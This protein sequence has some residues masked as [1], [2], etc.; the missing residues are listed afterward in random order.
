[1]DFE[2]LPDALV[3]LTIRCSMIFYE[4]TSNFSMYSGCSSITFFFSVEGKET[5]MTLCFER[6]Y[7][8]E[9]LY[10]NRLLAFPLWHSMSIT[11]ELICRGTLQ[12]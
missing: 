2:I 4:H 8:K 7:W 11:P 12:R 6:S 5:R 1:M 10:H 3:M 9:Q